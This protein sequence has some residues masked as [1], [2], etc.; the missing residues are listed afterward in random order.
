[1]RKFIFLLLVGTAAPA[2]AQTRSSSNEGQTPAAE[3]Q[4]PVDPAT[5]AGSDSAGDIIVTAQRRSEKCCVC[6]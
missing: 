6:P 4:V 3:G 5:S 1:M 2:V